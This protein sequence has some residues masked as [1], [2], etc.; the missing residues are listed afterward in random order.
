MDKKNETDYVFAIAMAMIIALIIFLW[1]YF[2]SMSKP[3]EFPPKPEPVMVQRI[4]Q[5]Y[6]HE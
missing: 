1:V 4:I 3:K 6:N 5:S 2:S